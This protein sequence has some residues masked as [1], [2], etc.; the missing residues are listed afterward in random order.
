MTNGTQPTQTIGMLKAR[1]AALGRDL[2]GIW[3]H[4]Q[5]LRDTRGKE[6]PLWPNWCF[7]P[8]TCWLSI[9]S[10]QPDRRRVPNIEDVSA[11]PA[12][13][14]LGTWRYTQGIYEFDPDLWASLTVSTV[15]GKLPA[16]VLVRLP[17]WCLY[18]T[19]PAGG[20]YFVHL[21]WDAKTG[22]AELR[23]LL[24]APALHPVPLPLTM[25]IG[26]WTVTEAFDRTFSEA[27]RIAA[28][29]QAHFPEVRVDHIEQGTALLHKLLPAVLYLCSEAPELAGDVPDARPGNPQRTKTKQG[30]KL[31]APPQPRLWRVGQQIGELLRR[32]SSSPE[33]YGR[34][35]HLRRAHWHGYWTGPRDGERKFQY[36]WM[37]P[38]M[39][40]ASRP[41]EPTN[42]AS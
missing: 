2:P 13:A 3:Q 26:P 30:P 6:L 21:E 12:I 15:Q 25:H 18:I 14:A 37:P 34:R 4:V 11:M 33:F 40:R 17:E 7:L 23:F 5:M 8:L 9:L 1:L 42:E 19:L 36:H 39:V 38:T 27:R 35:A 41:D 24:E 20:G 16:D 32:Q 28:S 31:F 10:H 29:R 22:R